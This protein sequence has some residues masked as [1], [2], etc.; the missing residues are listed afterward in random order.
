MNTHS[1][2]NKEPIQKKSYPEFIIILDHSTS[3]V[4]FHP[5]IE[6]QV[7]RIVTKKLKKHEELDDRC[8]F[9]RNFHDSFVEALSHKKR[10]LVVD[11]SPSVGL[12]IQTFIEMLFEDEKLDILCFA[13]F[14]YKNLKT[15]KFFKVGISDLAMTMEKTIKSMDNFAFIRKV[16]IPIGYEIDADYIDRLLFKFV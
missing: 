6:N 13:F 5:S 14:H 2:S 11:Y 4:V 1:I 12:Y 3:N 9:E 16:V 7:Y 8:A 10:V 15:Q